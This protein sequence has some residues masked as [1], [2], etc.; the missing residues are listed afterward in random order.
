MQVFSVARTS[1]CDVRATCSGATPSNAG[2]ARIFVP[3]ATTGAGTARRA[4]PTLT[5]NTYAPMWERLSEGQ[6][7]VLRPGPN[8]SRSDN[9]VKATKIFVDNY[10][11]IR[12]L[13]SARSIEATLAYAEEKPAATDR[14]RAFHSGGI[15]A[16]RPQHRARHP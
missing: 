4:I 13:G 9:P 1:R 8:S 2:V 12:M 5:Q 15:V 10:E 14:R 3:P 16:A 11:G 6:S 7:A